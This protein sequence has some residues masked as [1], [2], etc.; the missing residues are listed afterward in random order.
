MSD[1]WTING[2]EFG[3]CNCAYG[4]PCQFSAPST[5]GFCEAVISGHI[6]EGH[7]NETKLD[8]LN[9]VL[10][11]QWPGEI[12]AGNGKEQAII[13]ERADPAQREAIRKILYGEST[14]PGTTHFFVYNSTMSEVLDPLFAPIELSIDVEARKAKVHVPGLVTLEGNP[15][16]SPFSGEPT[17]ARIHLPEGFEYTYAEMG[18]GSSKTTA[19]VKIELADT[20]AQFNILHMNQDGVIR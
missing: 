2:V 1:R 9:W 4:C 18:N 11:V 8:D 15:M 16:I 12:A 6:V 20:Y 5:H 10:L 13:D 14:A 17:R 19:D 7:F 3:N